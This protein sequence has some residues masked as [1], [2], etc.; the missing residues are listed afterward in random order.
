[1]AAYQTLIVEA[2][3]TAPGVA[4]IRLNRPEALNALN[5]ALL[6]EL[7]QALAAAE[8]DDAVG[9]IV[10]TGSAK[11]FAAGADI[12]EMSDKT[13]AQMFKA[14]FFTAG[15]RA[16]D[17]HPGQ[18]HHRGPQQLLARQ[19]FVVGT[20]TGRVAVAH[21]PREIGRHL[22]AVR[23][24]A[25]GV[26][27]SRCALVTQRA[28]AALVAMPWVSAVGADREPL[29]AAATVRGAHRRPRFTNLPS[30]PRSGVVTTTYAHPCARKMASGS[31]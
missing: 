2:P 15:A 6:A 30:G 8:A 17:G 13:Y 5:T 3:E 27:K 4:L 26:T 19:R 11:A 10:L 20:H 16:V 28:G 14:D 1:M 21:L 7:A 12:K 9:C 25:I 29:V 18:G 23:P 31:P 24:V 22:G